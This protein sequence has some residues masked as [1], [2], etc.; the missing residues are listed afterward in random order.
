MRCIVDLSETLELLAGADTALTP[1]D[2][3]TAAVPTA[4]DR[5]DSES[6]LSRFRSARNS[7]AD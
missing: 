5:P 1:P 2:A 4:A 7:A 3:A 6:R